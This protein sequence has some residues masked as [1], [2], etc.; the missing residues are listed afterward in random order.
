MNA[1]QKSLDNYIMGDKE[2]YSP[3]E[4][5]HDWKYEADTAGQFRMCIVCEHE[6]DLA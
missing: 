6:E 4:D 2:W 3:C 1:F 5:G